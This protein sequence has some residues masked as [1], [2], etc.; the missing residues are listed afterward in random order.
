MN[1][2]RRINYLPHA[3]NSTLNSKKI[4]A[5]CRIFPPKATTR[6]FFHQYRTLSQTTYIFK[7]L[8][9]A[10]FDKVKTR[11]HL[12]S[13]FWVPTSEVLVSYSPKKLRLFHPDSVMFRMRQE[14]PLRLGSNE[15]DLETA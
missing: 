8:P 1:K 7:L 15:A 12:K 14:L 11:G 9:V 5:G 10:F 2:Y 4:K 6:L 13:A 3:S